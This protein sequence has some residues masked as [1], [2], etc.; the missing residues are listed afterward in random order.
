M[1][2]GPDAVA[3]YWDASLSEDVRSSFAFPGLLRAPLLVVPF[4]LPYRYLDR[5]SEPDKAM[6]GLGNGKE[7]WSVPYWLVDAAFAA[8]ALQ[9]LAVEL[10][11]GCCF[12][13]L[14]AQEASIRERFGIPDEACAVGTVAIGH[15]EPVGERL[16]HSVRRTRRPL[17]EV[18]H[19][20][21]W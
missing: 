4:G 9:L 6:T 10:G 12:F 20:D 17:G 8:M 7:Y 21:Y 1:L 2:D 13:G 11:L 14:F 5:Y 19:R 3:T 16:G 18:V 15:P